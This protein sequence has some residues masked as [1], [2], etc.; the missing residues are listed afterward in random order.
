[1]ALI[2]REIADSVD[3]S[4]RTF[5]HRLNSLVNP[6]CLFI[7]AG[8][9]DDSAMMTTHDVS[10]IGSRIR[11][12]LKELNK[13]QGDL[14][15]GLDVSDNAVSKWIKTGKISRANAVRAADFL[16]TTVDWLT[17]K[18]DRLPA[19]AIHVALDWNTL[20]EPLRSQIADV[21][22]READAVRSRERPKDPPKPPA[23]LPRAEAPHGQSV[24]ADRYTKIVLT[25]IAGLLA[26]IAKH[27]ELPAD[28]CRV[29][30]RAANDRVA[31]LARHDM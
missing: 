22:H 26:H 29:R 2:A 12:R 24:T 1:M 18:E 21:I 10:I 11:E 30:R 31:I 23:P 14:A 6:G 20:D 3:V 28:T 5:N 8:P 17:G 16:R 19:K 13:A 7:S 4:M 27:H 15:G 25:V 9:H